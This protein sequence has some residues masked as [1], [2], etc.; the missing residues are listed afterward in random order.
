M[1]DEDLESMYLE[2]VSIKNYRS[3]EAVELSRFGGLNILIGKNNAGKSNILNAVYAVFTCIRGGR[4]V[5]P[6]PLISNELNFFSKNTSDPIEIRLEFSLALAE[7]DILLR[8][9]A[10]E[11]P[12]VK[13]A[14]DGLDPSLRLAI[15]LRVTLD[16]SPF[17]TQAVKTQNPFKG[18]LSHGIVEK[19][20]HQGVQ[21]G[22]GPAV[23]ARGI[24]GRGSSRSGSEP[25]RAAPL[26]A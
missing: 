12:H 19:D 13:N 16:L 14:L 10:S 22:G 7:R 17:L 8:D 21:A 15:T 2:T 4:V 5:V 6:H 9:I 1:P 20:I 18:E 26:A 23:G 11:A 3:I 24:V 25:E